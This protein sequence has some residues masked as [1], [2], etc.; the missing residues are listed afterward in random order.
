MTHRESGRERLRLSGLVHLERRTMEG[1]RIIRDNLNRVCQE[2]RPLVQPRSGI[3]SDGITP[4]ITLPNWIQA[5]SLTSAA[6]T[7]SV[8]TSRNDM[9]SFVIN[10]ESDERDPD[11]Q[12]SSRPP[13]S[14]PGDSRSMPSNTS[15]NSPETNSEPTNNPQPDES[16][17]DL[18]NLSPEATSLINV[19][20]KYIPFVTI[21]LAKAVYDYS[22]AIL[23]FVGLYGT[24]AFYNS[25]L[26]AEIAQHSQRNIGFLLFAVIHL[27]FTICIFYY[28]YDDMKL[29]LSVVFIPPYVQPFT[30]ADLL[31]LVAVTDF[32][33][34]LITIIIKILV[35]IIPNYLFEA[36]KRGKWYLAIESS[37]QLYRS[38][39]PIQP[40]LY[41][42]L[43]SYQGP[44]KVV[45]VFLSAAYMVSKGSDL[46]TRARAWWA[47][48]LKLLENV[49]LG[50]SPDKEAL[51]NAGLTCPICHDDYDTPVLLACRHVFCESCVARWFDREQTCPLC[52]A[53]VVDDPSWRD[54]S[55]TYFTQLF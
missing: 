6:S 51:S 42:L 35:T 21:I 33:L 5:R 49:Q 54:G 20:K 38:L 9:E 12:S 46:M 44:Q 26:K 53:K 22:P 28:L 2:L 4:H 55:T 1:S 50:V 23:L 37:S 19:I 14:P 10:L 24:F 11:V 18:F 7:S 3:T 45:G 36:K 40:W 31:W 25:R 8:T 15:S 30:V 41:Y 17:T 27:V 34:K 39:V 52:R 47:S 13:G 48:M 32:I 16:V 29:Y 43:E